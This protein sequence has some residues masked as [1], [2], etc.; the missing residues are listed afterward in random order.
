M[1]VAAQSGDVKESDHHIR[2]HSESGCG[3]AAHTRR[4]GQVP[5]NN[6]WISN[7]PGEPTADYH[8]CDGTR[9]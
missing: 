2:G 7:E 6:R 1:C 3:R 8:W 5:T 4:H 9:W